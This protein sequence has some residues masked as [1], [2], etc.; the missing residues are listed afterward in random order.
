MTQLR[1]RAEWA[2]RLEYHCNA[3]CWHRC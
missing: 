1:L 2:L 3:E